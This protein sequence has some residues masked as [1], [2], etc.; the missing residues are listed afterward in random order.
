M[1]IF[2]SNHFFYS[3]YTIYCFCI[4]LHIE[5]LGR[6]PLQ[7]TN[8]Y[9]TLFLPIIEPGFNIVLQPISALLP[10]NAPNLLRLVLIICY[11]YFYLLIFIL[12]LKL[13]LVLI[14]IYDESSF[15]LDV[16]APTEKC[17]LTPNIESPT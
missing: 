1:N 14:L 6:V 16:I 2:I 12:I 10:T 13:K 7:L 11:F 4:N 17:A 9:I 15:K 3:F 8:G 5:F